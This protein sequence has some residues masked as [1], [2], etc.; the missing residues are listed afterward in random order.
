MAAAENV[1]TRQAQSDQ[2]ESGCGWWI[3]AR[4]KGR[5]IMARRRFQG[6]I[7][8]EDSSK[9]LCNRLPRCED[10]WVLMQMCQNSENTKLD[11]S[12]S[13]TGEEIGHKGTILR[14]RSHSEGHK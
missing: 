12:D 2:F 8:L 9:N 4:V 5:K 13:A 3:R 10:L 14:E 1:E 6:K 7:F 11:A